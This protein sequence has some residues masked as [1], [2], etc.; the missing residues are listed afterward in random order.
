MHARDERYHYEA[1][2]D[3]GV[4]VLDV[5]VE[6]RVDAG[7]PRRRFGRDGGLPWLLT[8]D[9]GSEGAS[10]I[11]TERRVTLTFLR[12]TNGFVGQVDSDAGCRFPA[13]VVACTADALEIHSPA[14]CAFDDAGVRR[15]TLRRLGLD[16]GSDTAQQTSDAGATAD[17]GEP[18][19]R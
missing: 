13:E 11:P 17:A 7:R 6:M 19:D 14:A 9:G 12:T 1:N 8:V 5:F 15:E 4:L 3:G 18:H 16:A 10:A 2:D